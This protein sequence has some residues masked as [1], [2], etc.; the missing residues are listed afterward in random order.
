MKFWQIPGEIDPA[1]IRQKI[2]KVG[3]SLVGGDWVATTAVNPHLYYWGRTLFLSTRDSSIKVGSY[4]GQKARLS[5]NSQTNPHFHS[6]AA[7]YKHELR[8]Y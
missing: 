5:S 7:L 8:R 1:S 6:T 4:Q 3:S 2:I